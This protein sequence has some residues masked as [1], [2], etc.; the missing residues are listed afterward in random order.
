MT[1]LRQFLQDMW[2]SFWFLPA[3]IVIA[4]VALALVLVNVGD[5]IDSYFAQRW[6]H[7][8]GAGPSGARELLATVAIAMV[9]IAGVVFSITI[10][11]LSLASSQY[12]SRVLSSFMRDHGNQAVLGIFVGVFAYCIM[13]LRTVRGEDEG[14]FVP[15]LAV[16][17]ALALAFVGM[18]VFIYFIHH[19]ATSIQAT[20]LLNTVTDET[21][22]AVDHLF[23]E[24]VGE[25]EPHEP[26]LP[27][28]PWK[29][30]YSD[31]TGYIQRLDTDGLLNWAHRRHTVV[32]MEYVIGQFVI[33]ST[34]LASVLGNDA[35]DSDRRALSE[36][37]VIGRHKTIEQDAAFGICQIVD[38]ALRSLAKNESTTA[39]MCVDH[40]TALL[41]RL[42]DRRIES[43]FRGRDGQVRLVTRGPTHADMIAEAFDQIRNNA[44]GNIAVLEGMF[45]ALRLLAD[46]T[47]SPARR[48]TLL[49]HAQALTELVSS[50]VT[51]PRDRRRLD[52]IS[53]DTMQRLSAIPAA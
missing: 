42:T 52:E 29:P 25:E 12:S 46:R 23:P 43:H 3:L 24:G 15:V 47:R 4:S 49:E 51:A 22:H 8:F 35:D 11:A 40:L 13:V 31:E 5:D 7:F 28:G 1:R 19:I 39:V 50:S 45:G 27:P 21:L 16:T 14:M 2:A 20:H 36:L 33:E 34:L 32:R 44:G 48:R 38:I 37:Y 9:T 6:P 10:V 18:A 30:V 26:P 41:V 53:S 17:F